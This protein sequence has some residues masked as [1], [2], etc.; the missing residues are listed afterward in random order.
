MP[1][2]Q[3]NIFG[4]IDYRQYLTS[5]RETEKK[6]NPGLTH[7]YL[8]AKLGQKNRTY[9][10]SLETGRKQIGP[11]VLDRL[12]KLIGLT[13]NR[14]K[15]FRALVGY[16]QPATY[17]EKEYWFEQIV[18]LNNTPKKII[19]EKTY[20]YFKKWYYTTIRTYLETCDFKNE[21]AAASKKLFGRVS[22]EEV[23][24]A[25]ANLLALG[26]I[27]P[28]EKGF[29]KPVDKVVTTDDSIKS[30]LTQCYN[31]SNINILRTIVEKDAPGTYE[32]RNL[33]FSVSSKGLERIRKRIQQLRAEIISIVHKDD[34]QADCVYK[35]SIH[36]YPET[37]KD[38]L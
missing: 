28:N 31:L 21:Y 33:T 13:G 3:P 29:L 27:G 14:A 11:E 38:L 16:A 25:I 4:F 9:F 8:C 2:P 15:Y 37:R 12:I 26:M 36:T 1:D 6:R 30:E 19:D 18:Q 35:V 7:E 17:D 32:S 34:E 20:A 24:D 10:N 22:P 5:W 23:K